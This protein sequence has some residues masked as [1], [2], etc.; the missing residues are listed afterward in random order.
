MARTALTKTS[1]SAN[2]FTADAAGNAVDPTNGHT[3]ASA[4]PERTLFRFNNTTASPKAFTVKAGTYPPAIAAGL[5]D[6]VVT[7]PAT[8]TQWV[9]PLES[10]RFLQSDGSLSVD[11]ASG[12]TGTISTFVVPKAT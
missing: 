8:T 12:T 7:V 1:L 4:V 6:L 5:G 2:A 11:V 9:G 3:V 10:G